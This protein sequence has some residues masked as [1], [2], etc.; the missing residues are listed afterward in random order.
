MFKIKYNLKIDKEEYESEYPGPS[1]TGHNIFILKGKN[2]SGKTTLISLIKLAFI[3]DLDSIKDSPGHE[4]LEFLLNNTEFEATLNIASY[5]KDTNV[6]IEYSNAEWK[7]KGQIN[8]KYIFNGNEVGYTT[9]QDKIDVLY[10]VPSAPLDKLKDV[11]YR[12]KSDFEDY[13][14]NC[15]K[16]KDNLGNLY[17]EIKNYKER[18]DKRNEINKKIQELEGK[19][20]SRRKYCGDL[21]S[22]FNTAENLYYSYKYKDLK[23]KLD[24]KNMEL[25]QIKNDKSNMASEEMPKGEVIKLQEQLANKINEAK[26]WLTNIEQII[27]NFSP[28]FKEFRKNLNEFNN[29]EFGQIVTFKSKEIIKNLISEIGIMRKVINT[30]IQNNE[31]ENIIQYQLLK[32]LKGL[33]KK[34]LNTNPTIPGLGESVVNI[35]QKLDA[36]ENQFKKIQQYENIIHKLNKTYEIIQDLDNF[37]EKNSNVLIKVPSAPRSKWQDREQHIKSLEAE[38]EHIKNEL[39][40][41][42]P[43]YENSDIDLYIGLDEAQRRYEELK[44]DIEDCKKDYEGIETDLNTQRALLKEYSTLSKPSTTLTL[45]EIESKIEKLETIMSR[46]SE[47]VRYIDSLINGNQIENGE[48]EKKFY[49]ALGE[50]LAAGL[51]REI[52][53]NHRLYP[54]KQINLIERF[55][56]S[57][58][59]ERISFDAIGS[60]TSALNSILM[61]IKQTDSKKKI[62]A[63]ID[64][65]GAM[66]DENFKTFLEDIKAYTTEGRLFLTIMTRPDSSVDKAVCEPVKLGDGFD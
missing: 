26:E 61:K 48:N 13:K 31:D 49:D 34:Y 39:S 50:Y 28:E 56:V 57:E 9:I 4:K 47:Y 30:K 54:I 65:I 27:D 55:Y 24:Q 44:K 42:L 15:K 18:E 37:V 14:E 17:T 38:I 64:E 41:I 60:G 21:E 51:I 11:L 35:L 40:E 8:A 29:I 32:E 36:E 58:S 66:D 33:L 22:K 6:D 52:Y 23:R 53:H 19:L 16:Y 63:L 25:E 46:L 45:E 20:E 3:K 12:I 10:E 7:A 1:D 5:N 59:G 2:D 43:K 62:I